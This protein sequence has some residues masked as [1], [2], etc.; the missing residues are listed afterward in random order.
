[1]VKH[2]FTAN[3]KGRDFVVGDIHGCFDAL[4][5]QMA[6]QDFNPAIDRV[7]SV[8]DLV[9]RG[10][11]SIVALQ[12]LK[13]PWFIACKG[14]HEEFVLTSD[15]PG[16][17]Q[18]WTEQWGGDWWLGL[19]PQSR[20]SCVDAFIALPLML[21]IELNNGLTVGLVHAEM[22]RNMT[23]AEVEANAAVGHYKTIQTML[24]GRRRIAKNIREPVLG[25]D[26]VIS[27]HT[28]LETPL[29]IGNSYFIDTGAYLGGDKG[30]LTFVQIEELLEWFAE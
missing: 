30:S 22:P 25:I 24:F 16:T 4:E 19:D 5:T 6:L 3:L 11:N 9:D 21:E 29:K 28:I 17:H 15:E 20:K 26:A 13:Q 2:A 1:M 18:L 14:N 7:F 23:W 10:P 12:Y 8:G 27:G